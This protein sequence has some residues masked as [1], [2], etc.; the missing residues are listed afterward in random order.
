MG[1]C[2]ENWFDALNTG[3]LD[4]VLDKKYWMRPGV[5]RCRENSLGTTCSFYGPLNVPRTTQDSFITGRGQIESDKCP[6]CG[7]R[8]LPESVFALTKDEEK[9]C[10]NMALLPQFTRQPKSCFNISEVENATHAWMPSNFQ[11]GYTGYNSVCDTHIQSREEARQQYRAPPRSPAEKMTSYG[12][13][14]Q[15][16]AA[17]AAYN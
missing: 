2:W 4:Y 3:T 1:G 14:N 8:Y 6:E 13:Y 17:M 11:K 10:Q 9:G 15:N 16:Y 5:S 12:S 7:V